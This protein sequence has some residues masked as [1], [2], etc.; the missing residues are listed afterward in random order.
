MPESPAI[1]V[2][3]RARR[4]Q[5]TIEEILDIAEQ[6]MAEEGVTG[7]SVAEVARR[8]GVQ[9]PS[10]YKYFPSLM[11]MY[12]ALFERGQARNLEVL[13]AATAGAEPGL[14]ALKAALEAGARWVLANR[15]LAQLMFW[16]PVPHFSPTHQAMAA[17]NEMIELQR[18]ALRDA[19]AAGQLGAAAD[20]EDA[21]NVLGILIVGTLTMVMANEP[22]AQWGEGR[23]SP[24]FPRLVDMLPALY[25]VE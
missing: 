21:V 17:S 24:L 1:P 2:D 18:N 12:D 16:R 13:R 20:S 10:L 22:D 15:A 6:V 5:E 7:L 14:P 9:P 8:L 11:A 23:F 19:V 3:R 25:P 4:R